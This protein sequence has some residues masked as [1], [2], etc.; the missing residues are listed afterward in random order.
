LLPDAFASGGFAVLY[1]VADCV[2]IKIVHFAR[3]A[4]SPVE[5]LPNT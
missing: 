3:N 2:K 1:P 5:I 4:D